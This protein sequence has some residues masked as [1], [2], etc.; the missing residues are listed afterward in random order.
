MTG[1][2]CKTGNQKE[3]GPVTSCLAEAMGLKKRELIS[4]VGA[5][6]KTTLM[7][8]LAKE[9]C[10]AGK[11]VVTTTT[12]KILEPNRE[13]TNFLFVDSDEMRVKD[14]VWR[15]V[16]QYGHLTVAR[17]K[18]GAAKL[19]GISADL[20]NDLWTLNEIDFILVEA[21]GSAGRPIKAPRPWEPVIP[22]ET[23]VVIGILGVDGLGKKVNEENAFYPEGISKITGLSEGE[24]LSSEGMALLITDSEGIFKGAPSSSRMIAFLN[25]IDIPSGRSKAKN[26]SKKIL[27]K[28]H[29]QIER[30]VLGQLRDE[31]PVAEV[32]FP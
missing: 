12:T 20:V 11:R 4:L 1:T 14:F 10:L 31:P 26:I 15:H 5:G 17:E 21:D 3:A 24:E 32:L 8:R 19:K 22:A 6:G 28:K 29:L 30:V 27:E 9:L 18:L 25:K 13:E 7:Y 23:T 2:G 16:H